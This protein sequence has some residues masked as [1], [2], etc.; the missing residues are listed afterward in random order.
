MV[1]IVYTGE[2]DSCSV[3]CK[4]SFSSFA[5]A[6]H[7]VLWQSFKHLQKLRC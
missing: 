6:E 7:Y 4:V 2:F 5:T 3:A 1:A